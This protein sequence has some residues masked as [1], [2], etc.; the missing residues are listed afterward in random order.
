MRD[1]LKSDKDIG[2]IDREIWIFKRIEIGIQ[3]AL[4]EIA[5][6]EIINKNDRE[7]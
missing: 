6:S 5:D 7:I 4:W 3:I 2:I 1:I